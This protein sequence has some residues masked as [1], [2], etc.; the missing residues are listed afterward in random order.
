MFYEFTRRYDAQIHS[1]CGFMVCVIRIWRL[2]SVCSFP[3]LRQEGRALISLKWRG[4]FLACNVWVT[5][6]SRG[7]ESMSKDNKMLSEYVPQTPNER[8]CEYQTRYE[9]GAA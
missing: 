7:K 5:S 1:L 6:R 4:T 3:A 8:L 9:Y 2:S